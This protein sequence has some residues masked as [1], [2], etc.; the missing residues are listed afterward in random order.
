MNIPRFFI[1][2]L[3]PFLFCRPGVA[4]HCAPITESYLSLISVKPSK[5]GIKIHC[6]YSKRG[7][8]QKQKYQAYLLAYLDSYAARVPGNAPKELVDPESVVTLHTQL[9]EKNQEG[10]YGLDFEIK[11]DDLARMMI[12]QG[13]LSEKDRNSNVGYGRYSDRIRLAVFVPFL[14]D[15]KYSVIK[16]LPAD[17]H[18]CNYGRERALLFQQLPYS[19]SIA[20]FEPTVYHLEINGDKPAKTEK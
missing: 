6:E 16:G 1:I 17:K 11:G 13:R 9:I 2:G 3:I 7:G 4:Q 14:D 10:A 15:S 5:D 8:R 19:F 18:E 12:K 20:Y